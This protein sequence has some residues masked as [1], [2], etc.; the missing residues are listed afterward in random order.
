MKEALSATHVRVQQMSPIDFL[1][2]VNEK[3]EDG[4]SR[5]VIYLRIM[6]LNVIS[7]VWL[8]KSPGSKSSTFLL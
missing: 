6:L 5:G 3:D 8:F 2:A 4:A 7:P 1:P